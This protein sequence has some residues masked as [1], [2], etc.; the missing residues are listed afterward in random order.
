M[1]SIGPQYEPDDDFKAAARLHQSAYRAKV[2]KVG[3]DE[4]GN[5]LTESAGR[6][7]VNYYDGLGV[8]DVGVGYL[9]EFSGFWPR[10]QP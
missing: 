1:S 6:A 10:R 9:R 8:R 2:L 4:Y 3:F 5:R 7:L